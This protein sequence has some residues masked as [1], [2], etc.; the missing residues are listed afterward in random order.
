MLN[1]LRFILT[2]ITATIATHAYSQGDDVDTTVKTDEYGSLYIVY[3]SSGSMWGELSDKSRKY[4]A[5]QTALSTLLKTDMNGRAIAFRAYGHRQKADCRDSE[6]IVP[7]S[8]PENAI[9]K[10]NEAVASIR[11]KG[12]T[13]ISY[14]LREALKDFESRAGDILLISD[15]IETCDI[16]PC[17]LMREWQSSNVNIR[18]HVVGVGLNEFERQ[19]MACIADTSGGKYFDADSTEGFTDAVTEAGAAIEEPVVEPDPIE[20]IG[21]YALIVKGTDETGR[22][23]RMIGKLHKADEDLGFI[24]SI[25]RQPVDGPGD[26]VVEAGPRLQDGTAYKPVKVSV[27]VSEPGDTLSLIHI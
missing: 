10:I 23:Y 20:P 16:D 5:V 19:A 22:S 11:P 4:E 26:Y 12:K 21:R 13:P 6:L 25:G 24:S 18:V 8:T 7:F 1:S 3:D 17:E 27:A 9:P 14:S 15:G 2:L